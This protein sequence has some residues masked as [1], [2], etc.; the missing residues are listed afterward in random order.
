M[1]YIVVFVS[2]DHAVYALTRGAI[3][4][5]HISTEDAQIFYYTEETRPLIAQIEGVHDWG[6]WDD[7]RWGRDAWNGWWR[8]GRDHYSCWK[9]C[10]SRGC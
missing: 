3:I 1:H 7:Y 9:L 10:L 2:E 4:S 5:D 6:C 8:R